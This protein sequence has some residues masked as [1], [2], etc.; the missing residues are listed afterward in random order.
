MAKKIKANPD[1]SW[2]SADPVSDLPPGT[3]Y[4]KRVGLKHVYYHPG[5]NVYFAV[6]KRFGGK[7]WRIDQYAPGCSVC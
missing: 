6:Y 5:K 1:F 7:V 4:I 2:E 3:R